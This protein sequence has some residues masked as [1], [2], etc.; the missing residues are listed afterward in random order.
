MAE[1]ASPPTPPPGTYRDS[2]DTSTFLW[3]PGS[4]ADGDA[5]MHLVETGRD[6][7]VGNRFTP[8]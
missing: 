2:F 7:H 8:W 5:D 6:S 3:P 1:S 4:I